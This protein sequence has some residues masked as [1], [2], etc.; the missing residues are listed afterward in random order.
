MSDIHVRQATMDDGTA[1]GVLFRRRVNVWQRFDAQ[2]QVEELPYDALVIYDRWLHGG[3]W[4]SVE[5]SAIFLSHLLCGGGKPFV[6]EAGGEV[7]GYAEIYPGDEPSP[8]S[9]HWH[10]ADLIA[11]TDREDVVKD[12]LMQYLLT[13]GTKRLAVTFS[14]Y[15][16]DATSFYEQYGLQ[17]LTHVKK[18]TIAAQAG[19]SFYKATE[20]QDVDRSQIAG[21]VMPMGRLESARCHWEALWPRLWD[22]FPQITARK[23][24]RLHF[25][26]AG[27][28]A[29]VCYQQ[30]LFTPRTADVYCWSPRGLT[31]QLLMAIR[32]WAYREDYRSL[33]LA[34]PESMNK[35]LGQNYEENPYK[36]NCY[37]IDL[38]EAVD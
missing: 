7:V 38:V 23:T 11:Q 26:A 19:Q 32:D 1:I 13:S 21:W 6:A 24:H 10:I 31:K 37:A 33:V 36:Q 15:D 29:F 35:L 16:S 5:T 18:Y 25:S 2:G 30:Q 17:L 3:A 9:A 28:E 12:A 8:Y 27:Q 20:Q 34:L 22:A 4:M 14:S